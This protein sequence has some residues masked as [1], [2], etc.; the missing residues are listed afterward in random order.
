MTKKQPVEATPQKKSSE[1]DKRARVSQANVPAYSLEDA[2]R[3]AKTISSQY[4]GKPTKPINVASAMNLS[5]NSSVFKMLTGASIAYGLTDG[6]YNAVEISL[7][8]LGKQIVTPLEEGADHLGMVAAYLKPKVIAEFTKKYDGSQIPRDDI[9]MNVLAEMGVPQ[10]RTKSVFEL[11][12]KGAESL[13]LISDIKGKK[14][15]NLSRNGG[16]PSTHFETEKSELNDVVEVVREFADPHQDSSPI[17]KDQPPNTVA[18]DGRTKRV[19]ITHGKNTDFIAPIKKLLTF[20]EL[21]AVVSIE[22]QSVSQPVPEKVMRD[23][24]SCGA[25]IIHVDGEQTL[26]DTDANPHQVLNPNVLIEIGAAMALYGRRFILIVREGVKL[27]S[28]LQ[29]LYE[30]RYSGTALD[31][32]ATIRLMEAI[33]KLKT[34][35]L[36][37]PGA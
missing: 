8:P 1:E 19:F 7:T 16:Q 25:A 9:G 17:T 32:D 12:V 18:K 34:E 11:I 22:I 28:N 30:V 15:L 4:G 14:Y 21:E 5:P 13:D 6:G 35:P 37:K 29:V 10:E 3:V 26:M 36:E 31:G 24:R 33:N 20:G 27:P 23:M 2:L